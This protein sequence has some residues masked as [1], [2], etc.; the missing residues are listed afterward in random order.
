MKMV[1]VNYGSAHSIV[2]RNSELYWNGWTIS[3]WKKNPDGY[4]KTNGAYRNNSW[5]V[6]KDYTM[7]QDGTWDV[8][9]KYLAR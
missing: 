3:E 1:N 2:D 4:F 6:K 8:P 9:A 5:G 7:N